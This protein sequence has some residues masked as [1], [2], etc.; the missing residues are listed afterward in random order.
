MKINHALNYTEAAKILGLLRGDVTQCVAGAFG[1][2]KTHGQSIKEC[3]DDRRDE[4]RR[5]AS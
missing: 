2:C 3:Q 4:D 1:V 5:N